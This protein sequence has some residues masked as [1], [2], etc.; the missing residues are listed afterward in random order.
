MLSRIPDKLLPVAYKIMTNKTWSLASNSSFC[1]TRS[2]LGI[3]ALLEI[4]QSCKLDHEVSWFCTGDQPATHPPNHPRPS[5]KSN[6]HAIKEAGIWWVTLGCG[7]DVRKVSRR[8]LIGACKVSRGRL[9][10]TKKVSE[11]FQHLYEP[12]IYL[13]PY[14]FWTQIILYTNCSPKLSL[15]QC[16]L[17]TKFLWAQIFWFQYFL[18]PGKSGQ[19]K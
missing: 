12:K 11:K 6:F 2:N 3:S 10:G 7:E 1:H 19:F 16:F 18:G 13:G 9:E 17:D 14:I 4:L 5:W 15:T 8:C